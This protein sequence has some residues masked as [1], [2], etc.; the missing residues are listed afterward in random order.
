MLWVLTE[1][2]KERQTKRHC[3]TRRKCPEGI[4][5]VTEEGAELTG[6]DPIWINMAL[7]FSGQL[8]LEFTC[9][10]FINRF[11]GLNRKSESLVRV[12]QDLYINEKCAPG[13]LRTSHVREKWVWCSVKWFERGERLGSSPTRTKWRWGGIFGLIYL[14]QRKPNP[15]PFI[16]MISAQKNL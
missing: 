3:E 11:Q 4:T 10:P 5:R 14:R 12:I 13:I 1:A 9:L 7:W 15:R 16:F 6:V 8:V 2:E